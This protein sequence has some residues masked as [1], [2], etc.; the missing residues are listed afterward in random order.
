MLPHLGRLR[1]EA[2]GMGLGRSLFF[3]TLVWATVSQPKRTSKR[4][5]QVTSVGMSVSH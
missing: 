4:Q 1:D 5:Q 3:S 2:D